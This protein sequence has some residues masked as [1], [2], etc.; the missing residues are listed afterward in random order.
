MVEIQDNPYISD[1]HKI[2][3]VI[4]IGG[5]KIQDHLFLIKSWK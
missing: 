3:L 5:I 2:M 4:V 1:E